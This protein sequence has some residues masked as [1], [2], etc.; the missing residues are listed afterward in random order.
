MPSSL[1]RARSARVAVA[2][3]AVL[4]SSLGLAASPATAVVAANHNP[5]LRPF[6]PAADANA[7]TPTPPPAALVPKVEG[8]KVAQ[9]PGAKAIEGL[10]F[11]DQRT[12]N[13]GN[14]FSLEP[15]DQALCAGNGLV[16]EGVNNV[17]QVF[18]RG[19]AAASGIQSYDP[20]W[21]DGA[22]EILRTAN[23]P[24][25]GPFV[26]DPKCTFDPGTKRF[27]MTELQLGTDPATGAFNGDSFVDIAVSRSSTPGTSSAD[28]FIYRIN[29]RNDGTQGTPSH[30]G[31]PCL[32]DQP[33][34]GLDRYGFFVT[35]NE[36]PITG[37]GFNGAQAYAMDKVALTRGTLKV[38][39]FEQQNPTLAEGVAYSVQPAT[40][41]STGDWS[42]A[43]GGTE[44]AL[45]ALDFNGT[46][47]NRIA[48]WAM[49]NTSSLASPTPSVRLSQVVI[50]SEVYAT[51]PQVTQKAGPTPLGD[52]V[53]NKENQLASNDDRMNQVVFAGGRLYSGVNTA[54][55][56]E[57]GPTTAGIAYFVV[58]PKVDKKGLSARVQH[59][60]Y[61]AVAGQSVVYPSIGV[62]AGG[63]SAAMTFTLAGPAYFPSAAYVRL[64]R[65]GEVRGP[66]TVSAAGAAPADG[67]T[68]YAAYGGSGVERWGDYSAAVADGD[69]IW[70][71]AEYVP[72]TF[73][74][75]QLLANWGTAITT[76]R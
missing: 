21:N 58:Q 17:F 35:T 24:V 75:P 1:L 48:T 39:R 27:F 55:R 14:S 16:I 61:V 52:F 71:A 11:K 42:D 10:T 32:G 26:S 36:F 41:P 70:M 67:Y 50:K 4:V 72:G 68:G 57:N 45:S 38:Q 2:V 28:W 66:V 22:A 51:P 44:Y 23:P 3:A 7:P 73:G 43:A 74:Y 18:T 31:C 13:G 59:Q 76:V 56:T 63:R 15:P 8:V 65:D 54:V 53:K 20:F 30:T 37:A 46:N 64:G 29:V 25:Y 19:G 40:S 6:E 9:N 12:A 33:L 60:D 47:D 5:E 49:T 62:T 69:T 34:I